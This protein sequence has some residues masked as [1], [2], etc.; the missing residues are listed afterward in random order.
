MAVLNSASLVITPNGYKANKLYS[1]I[2]TDGL[3]DMTFT[4]AGDTATRVN[5]SGLIETV[6]ANKPRLDYTNS[7]CP[8]LLLEPQRTNLALRSQEFGNIS[9]NKISSSASENVV[10]SPDG[11]QNADKLVEDNTLAGHAFYNGVTST[12]NI[13]YTLSIFLKADGSGRNLRLSIYDSAFLNGGYVVFNSSSATLTT[14]TNVGDG[15]VNSTK[16]ETFGN[17]WFRVSIT[18][19]LQQ[20]IIRAGLFLQNGSNIGI[21]TGDGASG[22]YLWGAQI[23]AGAYATSYIPTTTA[24][25][26]RN[27]DIASKTSASSLIGQTEGT[28]FWDVN[29]ESRASNISFAIKNIGNTGFIRIIATGTLIQCTV[30]NSSTTTAAIDFTN[31]NTGRFKFAI[32]YK[33]DDI[34]FYANGVLV[35]TDTSSAIPATTDIDL[36]QVIS[37]G[38]IAKSNTYALWKTRLSNSDLAT[39]T[40]L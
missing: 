32:G 7:T 27:Q 19:T 8:K 21:Y 16:I 6:L 25:V 23:E 17:G 36:Y 20:T 39:L 5:P 40:T 35:G 26:T 22:I 9:W 2:P 33:N 29:F 28:M 30:S 31:S 11:T 3:G 37:N 18:A 14:Q 12:A 1:V 4:R 38:L 34:V 15:V 24:T 13:P 10:I